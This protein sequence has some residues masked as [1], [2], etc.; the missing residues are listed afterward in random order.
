M[1]EKHIF[2]FGVGG[3]CSSTAMQRILNSSNEVCIWGEQQ[4][5]IDDILCIIKRVDKFS[6]DSTVIEDNK[7]FHQCLRSKNHLYPHYPFMMSMGNLS[8]LRKKLIEAIIY[9]LKAPNGI[10]RFGFKDIRIRDIATLVSLREIFENSKFIFLF[11]N[12]INQWVS[13]NH[14]KW[15]EYGHKLEDFLEEYQNISKIMLEYSEKY[16]NYAFFENTSIQN[17]QELGKLL[18]FLNIK[19]VDN[20]VVQKKYINP[21]ILGK[22]ETPSIEKKIKKSDA[23]EKYRLMQE[24]VITKS[25]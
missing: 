10:V 22:R 25:T 17:E 11:R 3:R 2:I 14:Y 13:V 5:I 23:F 1:M 15:W 6:Q 19:E 8:E 18:D 9:N 24:K 4:Y 12:P 16:K 20:Q 7:I 21:K